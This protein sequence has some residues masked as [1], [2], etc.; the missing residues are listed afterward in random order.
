M[1]LQLAGLSPGPLDAAVA[2]P[3][4]AQVAEMVGAI[5]GV[6]HDQLYIE[7][8]DGQGAHLHSSIVG[9]HGG[10]VAMDYFDGVETYNLVEPTRSS[11]ENYTTV[12]S[13]ESSVD[14][15]D[16]WLVPLDRAARALWYL[17]L[18]GE[19]DPGLLWDT[20][21]AIDFDPPG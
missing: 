9:G 21:S 17:L 15:L 18:T 14:V 5:D 1:K 19:L 3:T 8:S 7:L 4:F 2:A 10:V 12:L 16:R 11:S 20:L 13:G 6:A